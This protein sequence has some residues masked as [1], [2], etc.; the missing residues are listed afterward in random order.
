MRPF[1][2]AVIALLISIPY[3]GR[4]AGDPAAAATAP[5]GPSDEDGP[6]QAIRKFATQRLDTSRDAKDTDLR[7]Q[8]HLQFPCRHPENLP[9]NFVIATVPDPIA[10]HLQ[11]W[12][13]RSVES[14]LA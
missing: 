3:T 4:T 9:L 11:L 1:P 13:D 6:C 8:S 7:L 12:F 5:G 14:I 10:T 2:L